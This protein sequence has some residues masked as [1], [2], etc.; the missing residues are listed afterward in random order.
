MRYIKKALVIIGIQ[1]AFAVGLSV[2]DAFTIPEPIASP[3]VNLHPLARFLFLIDGYFLCFLL[4]LIPFA[5]L[6]LISKIRGLKFL[7]KGGVI[8]SLIAFNIILSILIYLIIPVNSVMPYLLSMKGMLLMILLLLLSLAGYVG[9]VMLV[10]WASERIGRRL[11][12]V[13]GSVIIT[14]GLV[15]VATGYLVGV[16]YEPDAYKHKEGDDQRLNVIIISIDT[17]R[18]DH[19]SCYGYEGCKTPNIDEFAGKCVVF[20]NCI[21]PAPYTAPSMASILTGNYPTVHNCRYIPKTPINQDIKTISEILRVHG[22]HTEFYTANQAVDSARGFNRGFDYYESWSFSGDIVYYLPQRVFSVVERALI[23]FGAKSRVENF[24]KTEWLSE[25]IAPR[26][27]KLDRYAPFFLWF[28][29]FD[30]HGPY[31]PPQEFIPA[32]KDERVRLDSIKYELNKKRYD[33][34]RG[35]K[36]ELIKLYDGDIQYV[37]HTLGEL[38]RIIEEEGFFENTIVILTAD[39]GEEFWEHNAFG[40]GHCLYPEVIRIPLMIYL[41][42]SLGCVSG[43]IYDYVSLVDIAP[44]ILDCMGLPESD[45]M[46]GRSILKLMESCGSDTYDNEG[47]GGSDCAV[48]SEFIQSRFVVEGLDGEKKGIYKDDYHLIYTI[49]SGEKELYELKSDPGEFL[50]ISEE[51]EDTTERLY[52]ELMEWYETNLQIVE[53]LAPQREIEMDEEEREM[54]RGLGY[55]Y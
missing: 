49:A 18:K 33:N 44:T 2:I 37:D 39:H 30:P 53:K 7:F 13:L 40:H 28:H 46:G 43:R 55:I 41:P 1:S 3:M 45:G 26:L 14:L 4:G 6:Y 35:E 48:F 21:A 27:V 32:N 12:L 17:L 25:K 29:F 47:G 24:D 8:R 16:I 31:F 22:Y 19:L 10:R 54:M 50:D 5:L 15:M 23:F 11:K 52:S 51:D 9:M 36:E 20:E 34:C 42:P 38:L